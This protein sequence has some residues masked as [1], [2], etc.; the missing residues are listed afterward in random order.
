MYVCLYVCMSHSVG[1]GMY[2]I[3]VLHLT[4]TWKLLRDNLSICVQRYVCMYVCMY[5]CRYVCTYL[6]TYQPSTHVYMYAPTYQPTR[7]IIIISYPGLLLHRR[8]R[9]EP[10]AP[11]DLPGQFL[12]S[13]GHGQPLRGR[14]GQRLAGSGFVGHRGRP[15]PQPDPSQGR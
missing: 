14:H 5:V 6:P 12:L 2:V 4:L 1:K 15:V 7:L 3:S 13:D 10:A 9:S 11:S 8:H